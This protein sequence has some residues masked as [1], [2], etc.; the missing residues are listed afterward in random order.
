MAT[1]GIPSY[2]L[3]AEAW[4][5]G[6][7]RGPHKCNVHPSAVVHRGSVLVSRTRSKE[8]LIRHACQS[9]LSS[10]G[11]HGMDDTSGLRKSR[12]PRDSHNTNRAVRQRSSS[13]RP[14]LVC[15]SAIDD[16]RQGSL[17]ARKTPCRVRRSREYDALEGL[18][19]A[20]HFATWDPWASSRQG[21]GHRV[22]S[23]Q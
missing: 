2:R 1:T 17:Y 22:S 11:G 15:G 7:C 8:T 16:R 18:P 6:R 12:S 3:V 23:Q 10:R 14:R 4:Q 5:P 20:R 21:D 9:L 13:P 19:M